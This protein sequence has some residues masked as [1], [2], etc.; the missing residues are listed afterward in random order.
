M[1]W[2]WCSRQKQQ[3]S[4]VCLSRPML[5]PRVDPTWQVVPSPFLLRN[6]LQYTFAWLGWSAHFAATISKVV[7]GTCKYWNRHGKA[8]RW[9]VNPGLSLSITAPVSA[10]HLRVK[11]APLRKDGHKTQKHLVPNCRPHCVVL[12][13]TPYLRHT[14]LRRHSCKIVS[15][16]NEAFRSYLYCTNDPA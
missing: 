5:A 1:Y 6:R 15:S 8:G 9:Y 14:V 13:S 2:S 7:D 10:G 11:P 3:N 16:N 12:L 4:R